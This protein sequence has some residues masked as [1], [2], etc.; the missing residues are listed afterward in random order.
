MKHSTIFF[1]EPN[2]ETTH[3]F[4][5]LFQDLVHAHNLDF[6]STIY[7]LCCSPVHLLTLFLSVPF[8]QRFPK[9]SLSHRLR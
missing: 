9:P 2:K 4:R 5:Y 1:Q 8:L 3:L 6:G 7:G